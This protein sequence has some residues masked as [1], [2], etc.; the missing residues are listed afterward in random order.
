MAHQVLEDAVF[1][2]GQRQRLIIE[3][4][5]LAVEVQQQRAR[6][7]GRLDEATGT[8]QQGIE[9]GLQLFELERFDHV[10]VSPGGQAFDL[11][12]P[13]AARG[14]D[15][16]RKALALG[17]QLP[18]QVQAAHAGQAQV[19]HRQV[20]V[21]LLGLVQGLLGVGHRFNHMPALGQATVQVMTQQGFILNHQQFHRFLPTRAGA[22]GS[23][24]ILSPCRITAN[25]PCTCRPVRT[26]SSQGQKA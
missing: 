21:E 17:A 25:R 5:L 18:D 15:Q 14:E 1:I 8:T 22:R 4:C 2:G 16:D 7:D 9:A 3:G 10:V 23:G 13:V 11:V 26:S 19:D 24:E 6:R 12:L 20:M